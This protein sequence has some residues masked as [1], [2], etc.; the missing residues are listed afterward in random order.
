MSKEQKRMP[1][2]TYKCNECE[3]VFEI[4][5]SMDIKLKDCELCESLESL[6]RVPSSTF[7]TTNITTKDNKKV[8]DVVKNH[9]EEA[10]KELV[11]EQ[12]KL[13]GIEY[14]Q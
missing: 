1:R 3:E 14:K 6:T 10:K 7:I 12:Q 13:K 2:Y 8:G 11:S 5:H 4:N 9:I